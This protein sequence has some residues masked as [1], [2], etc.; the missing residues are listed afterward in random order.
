M[1]PETGG[2]G[3][4]L[5][6]VHGSSFFAYEEQCVVGG[7]V[8]QWWCVECSN[9]NW[10]YVRSL[11]DQSSHHSCSVRNDKM[12]AVTFGSQ[13]AAASA[14]T[15]AQS[16]IFV[17]SDI[18]L[19]LSCA[20]LLCSSY[21]SPSLSFFHDKLQ[22]EP[23]I[24]DR[25]IL[26]LVSPTGREKVSRKQDVRVLMWIFTEIAFALPNKIRPEVPWDRKEWLRMD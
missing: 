24:R 25:R 26:E 6:Q 9:R 5:F 7:F 14:N 23:W 8:C 21:F 17:I 4:I 1:Q 12:Q 18:T 22:L 3:G 10:E 20:S 2:F 13:A 15:Q 19:F 16:H 11:L